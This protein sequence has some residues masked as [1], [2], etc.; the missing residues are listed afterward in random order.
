VKINVTSRLD[1]FAKRKIA[2]IHAALGLVG[3][4]YVKRMRTAAR[5]LG[6]KR[7]GYYIS[8]MAREVKISRSMEF[9]TLRV[10]ARDQ[11]AHLLEKGTKR[12]GRPYWVIRDALAGIA[13]DCQKAIERA[14]TEY[15]S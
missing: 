10:G 11:K 5:G 2:A 14:K 3:E 12:G 9:V 6:L 7:T 13:E 8:R 15:E 1:D 4:R